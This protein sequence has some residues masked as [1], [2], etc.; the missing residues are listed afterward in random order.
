MDGIATLGAIE[1][2]EGHNSTTHHGEAYD[3]VKNSTR[4]LTGAYTFLAVALVLFF[5]RI[6]TRRVLMKKLYVDDWLLIFAICM[7]FDTTIT[8]HGALEGG[9][10]PNDELNHDERRKRSKLLQYFF[11]HD[12]LLA[13]WATKMSLLW[14]YTRL[15][16]GIPG[17][18]GWYK[19]GIYV[20]MAL[21]SAH[22]LTCIVTG[23]FKCWPVTLVWDTTQDHSLTCVNFVAWNVSLNVIN[24]TTDII[25]LLLPIPLLRL[26]RTGP[27]QRNG[28]LVV[29][30]L[31]FIP[32]VVSI[33]RLVEIL[34]AVK[35]HHDTIREWFVPHFNQHQLQDPAI[36]IPLM[37][38]AEVASGIAVACLPTLRPLHRHLATLLHR[39][40]HHQPKP[41]TQSSSSN[42]DVHQSRQTQPSSTSASIQMSTLRRPSL[43]HDASADL[44]PRP[45]PP[46]SGLF[47]W[48]PRPWWHAHVTE[49]VHAG[50]SLAVPPVPA[51][52]SSQAPAVQRVEAVV[53]PRG[54][55]A[56]SAY[57][58]ELGWE[59]PDTARLV[60]GG[61]DASRI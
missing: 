51:A 29:F 22:T 55:S 6:Y 36:W 43:D 12:Y 19:K 3:H 2:A 48:L 25:V 39:H 50:P 33:T 49:V 42:S 30:G 45:P 54:R 44:T 13:L 61:R 15:T 41:T 59:Q 1:A 60:A 17:L 47:S 16:S 21:M 4:M 57:S 7:F 46:R 31:G 53:A 5:A 11:E 23:I 40:L 34:V 52:S 32:I 10:L 58:Y 28:M 38:M 14:M 37:S 8:L 24:T 9:F 56:S 35:S 18:M 26:L 20:F 27:Q